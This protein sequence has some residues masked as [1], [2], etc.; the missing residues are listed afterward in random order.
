[1]YKHRVGEPVVIT[2]HGFLVHVEV[3]GNVPVAD[4]QRKLAEALLF[5]EGVGPV[6]VDYM[7]EIEVLPEGGA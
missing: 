5:T 4:M 2:G 1:M 7:G 6:D 3:A